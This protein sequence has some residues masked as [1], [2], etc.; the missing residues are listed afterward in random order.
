[1]LPLDKAIAEYEHGVGLLRDCYKIL[2]KAE[3]K[4][5]L[6]T[7]DGK[8]G[9]KEENFDSGGESAGQGDLF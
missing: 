3:K 8:G 5:T 1:D 7:S 2:E 4:I 9:M 6:L